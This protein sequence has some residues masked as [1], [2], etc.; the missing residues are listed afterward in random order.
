MKMKTIIR[1]TGRHLP[2]RLVTN[3]QM[4]QWMDTSEEWI[5]QRTGIEQRY[6]IPEAGGVGGSDLALAA[7]Q[8]AL[9]RA[10]WTAAETGA[11]R[12]TNNRWTG[13]GHDCTDSHVI[14]LG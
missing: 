2:E 6:W 14:L 5:V 1:G 11:V 8:I 12:S 9:E 7:S 10:G 3:A 13:H 4:T